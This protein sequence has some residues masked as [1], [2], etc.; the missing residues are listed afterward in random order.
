MTCRVSAS[1]F[2]IAVFFSMVVSD[3]YRTRW[4]LCS[5]R[6]AQFHVACSSDLGCLRLDSQA[7]TSRVGIIGDKCYDLSDIRITM[8]SD[9][10]RSP[11]WFAHSCRVPEVSSN[12]AA[13]LQVFDQ[14]VNKGIDL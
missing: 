14:L 1:G 3:C 4:I 6:G 13:P 10:I 7:M 2:F 9:S 8:T 11:S 12:Q 5:Q